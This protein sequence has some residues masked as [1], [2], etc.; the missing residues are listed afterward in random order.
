MATASGRTRGCTLQ[1]QGFVHEQ[2]TAAGAQG[3]GQPSIS[4]SASIFLPG[5]GLATTPSNEGHGG[6]EQ[7]ATTLTRPVP[8]RAS[9]HQRDRLCF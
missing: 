4:V 1:R 7:Q 2:S 3:P 8:G 6:Q 9:P 5:Q